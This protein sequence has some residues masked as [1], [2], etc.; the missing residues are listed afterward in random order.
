MNADVESFVWYVIDNGGWRQGGLYDWMGNPRPAYS[1]LRTFSNLT[2]NTTYLST[3]SGY[4]DAVEAFA[5][6]RS[7]NEQVHI[8]WARTDD[9]YTINAPTAKLIAAYDI[10]GNALSPAY[11]AGGSTYWNIGIDPVYI[12]R[13]P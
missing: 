9:I 4:P 11:Q 13:R 8:V 12:V 5:L 2:R 1:A 6:R 7:S 10:D 3:A